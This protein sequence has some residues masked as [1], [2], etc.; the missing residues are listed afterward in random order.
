[1]NNILEKVQALFRDVLDDPDLVVT[2]ESNAKN[3]SGW[4]SLSHINLIASIET[5]FNIEFSLGELENMKNLGEMID[6]INLKVNN[7]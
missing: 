4:D 6:V 3:V 7:N 2:R 1:M 5:E